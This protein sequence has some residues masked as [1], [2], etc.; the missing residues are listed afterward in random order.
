M[1][2]ILRGRRKKGKA[3]GRSSN[4]SLA[5]I[6]FPYMMTYMNYSLNN[7]H[8]GY[9]NITV[10][11]LYILRHVNWCTLLSGFPL[12][13]FKFFNNS[14][15]MFCYLWWYFFFIFFRPLTKSYYTWTSY[16]WSAQIVW[17]IADSWD[18]SDIQGLHKFTTWVLI[19][20]LDSLNFPIVILH[21]AFDKSIEQDNV[22][23]VVVGGN[24]CVRL[25]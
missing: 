23:M 9:F 1:N 14:V 17:E 10:L 13:F 22:K 25:F 4:V 16:L 15:Q 3:P 2:F 12:L 20:I 21:V 8:S 19:F 24:F 18:P 5:A 6:N 11:G 7:N